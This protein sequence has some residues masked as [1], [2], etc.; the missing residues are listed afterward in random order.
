[1]RRRAGDTSNEERRIIYSLH[2]SG[3]SYREIA[4]RLS[5]SRSTAASIIQR[6]KKTGKLEKIKR[7][8]RKEKL[9]VRDQRRLSRKVKGDRR[10]SK[11]K[12]LAEFIEESGKGIICMRTFDRYANKLGLRRRLATKSQVLGKRHRIARIQWVRTRINLT[13][14]DFW[15]RIIFSDECTIRVGQ[16]NRIYV[17]KQDGEGKHRPNVYGGSI[18]KKLPCVIILMFGELLLGLGKEF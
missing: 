12:V 2:Q 10:S 4:E 1:M 9:S 8:G 16:R 5:K 18:A 3:L 13:I 17:W 15:S 6:F 7:T 14:N 11:R